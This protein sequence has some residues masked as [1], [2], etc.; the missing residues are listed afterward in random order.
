MT[1][2]VVKHAE[3]YYPD[4]DD[5]DWVLVT[6]AYD[7]A[8]STAR[9][10]Y[11]EENPSDTADGLARRPRYHTTCIIRIDYRMEHTVVWA[12]DLDGAS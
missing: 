8:L 7:L 11:D 4:P 9:R 2:Y 1:L 5:G 10:L 3:V 12:G 6:N